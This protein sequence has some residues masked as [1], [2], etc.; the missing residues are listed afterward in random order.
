MKRLLVWVTAWVF[1]LG[2][3][4]AVYAETEDVSLEIKQSY[5]EDM[6]GDEVQ[7]KKIPAPVG[8]EPGQEGG[9]EK[10][11]AVEK[12][13]AS[14]T[15]LLQ[16]K[17]EE[18]SD[19]APSEEKETT[20][21]S[22]PVEDS[23]D[24]TEET[25][26]NGDVAESDNTAET[27]ENNEGLREDNPESSLKKTDIAIPAGDQAFAQS[28]PEVIEPA[29]DAR[30][31]IVY[32]DETGEPQ[33]CPAAIAVTMA[34]TSWDDAGETGSWYLAEGDVTIGTQEDPVTVTVTGNVRLILA[35]G[36]KLTVYGGID[37]AQ[38]QSFT[39]YAQSTGDAMG[40]LTANGIQNHAGI[41]SAYC[42]TITLN[43]GAVTAL[44]NV[45]I[46]SGAYLGNNGAVTINGGVVEATATSTAGIDGCVTINGGTV[47]ATGTGDGA[48]IGGSTTEDDCTVTINGG[49]VTAF[50]NGYG[51]AIGG[52][53]YGGDNTVVINGGTVM[54]FCTVGAF[55]GAAIGGGENGSYW[56]DTTTVAIHGG[57]VT[58]SIKSDAFDGA[59]IGGG[60][61]QAAEITITGGTV[62]AYREDGAGAGIGSGCNAGGA[63]DQGKYVGKHKITITGGEVTVNVKGFGAAIGGG[64]NT[65]GGEI[66]ITGGEI[67]ATSD[68]VTF[69]GAAIGGGRNRGGGTIRISGG[70]IT[71][72]NKSTAAGIG[73]GGFNGDG[74]D[75]TISG[76]TI[77]ASSAQA[78][79]GIGGGIFGAGGHV[80]ISG[81]VVTAV[82][83]AEKAACGI[84]PG[85]NG[86]PGTL[87][88]LPPRGWQ[89]AVTVGPEETSAAA[90]TRS[91]FA[92]QAEI[93]ALVANERY[94]HSEL[95]AFTPAPDDGADPDADASAGNQSGGQQNSTHA[96]EMLPESRTE[97][98]TN[99]A[100]KVNA[101]GQTVLLAGGAIPQTGDNGAPG[102]WAALMLVS[103]AGMGGLVWNKRRRKQ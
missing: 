18:K 38:E 31:K 45:G 34:D 98:E 12:Q 102:L 67:K 71:A 42:G 84:G 26:S 60:Y 6:P 4:T 2:M 93:Q 19:P 29:A 13:P 57:T 15:P 21:E 63:A 86:A 1:C 30:T 8:E 32:L 83:G 25:G 20:S 53:A 77:S 43:G 89:F 10:Q 79:A 62:N 61:E 99:I 36:A 96:P 94:F 78:G 49:V 9:T 88:M 75:I 56:G 68:G 16:E 100:T 72:I 82:G 80:C 27:S 7:D 44:G 69:S 59:V 50:S 52:A 76:G 58:A 85:G 51:A 24:T 90:L 33:T 14:E 5:T 47:T 3:T 55:G 97:T 40:S 39:V 48:G 87:T 66:T 11:P 23:T 64:D 73:G 54:A 35:D 17:D 74:G 92:E 81:G 101:S 46:G 37:V 65:D 95:E 28:A 22:T 41:G 70:N 103:A 91:P